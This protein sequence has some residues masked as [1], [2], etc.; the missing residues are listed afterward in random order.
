MVF[1]V[2]NPIKGINKKT[3]TLKKDNISS[4]HIRF[5]KGQKWI[6][7]GEMVMN[8]S[9]LLAQT[10][11]GKTQNFYKEMRHNDTR[12]ELKTEWQQCETSAQCT[13]IVYA[14]DV[15]SVNSQHIGEA[16]KHINN[17]GLNPASFN[18]LIAPT[19]QLSLPLCQENKCGIWSYKEQKN[20]PANGGYTELKDVSDESLMQALLQT[21][22]Y[23]S[24]R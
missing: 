3:Y 1:N 24:L 17:K 6:F 13:S 20:S 10:I 15:T 16:K 21:Y 9:V 5:S 22:L 19:G 23:A 18:C 11:N 2:E 8:P 7:A 12:T 14:C 4:C